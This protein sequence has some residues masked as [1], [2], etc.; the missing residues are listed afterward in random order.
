MISLPLLKK[1]F[2]SNWKFLL[3]LSIV[4]SFYSSVIITMFDPDMASLLDGFSKNMPELMQAFGMSNAGTDFMGFVVSYFY[5]FFALIFPL[6]FVIAMSSRLLSK[7]I[8]N[9]SLAYLLATPNKRTTLLLTQ[10][11]FL[12]ICLF[13]VACVLSGVGIFMV[14]LCFPDALDVG[15][16]FLLNVNVFAIQFCI[17]SI[18]FFISTVINDPRRALMFSIAFP[19]SFYIMHMLANLGGNMDFFKYL[20]VYTLYDPTGLIAQEQNAIFGLLGLFGI[21]FVLYA[22]SLSFFKKRD[23]NV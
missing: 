19:V 1:E 7:Y 8:D 13:V 5:G 16:Y 10:F 2:R 11:V 23:L 15:K 6:I 12:W 17:G 20:T 4:L 22:L 9:G 21:G 14:S 18:C 3:V